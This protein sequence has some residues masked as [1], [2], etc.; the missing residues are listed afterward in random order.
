MTHFAS[1]ADF[2]TRQ[3]EKQIDTFLRA[4]SDLN[5]SGISAPFIHLS[6]TGAI[7]YGRRQAWHNLVRPGHA[8]YGYTS[9]ARGANAPPNLLNVEPALTWKAAVLTV[10][11]VEAGALIG[12]GG[13]FRATKPTRIAVLAVGYA[14]GLPHRLSNRGNVIVNGRAVPILGAVSMDVT[15]IDATSSPELRP[16]DSVTLLGSEG[17]ARIDAQDIAR[18]AGTISY[19]VLCAISSRVKRVYFD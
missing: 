2:S 18:V 16:G 1:V 4:C 12:Y 19:N 10:K 17:Q 9:P 14:D 7:A 3:T 11:D 13:I 8:I 6:S 15:T 5:K